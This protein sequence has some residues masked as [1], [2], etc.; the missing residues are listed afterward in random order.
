MVKS[1]LIN[2]MR[3]LWKFRLNIHLGNRPKQN[4]EI[5]LLVKAVFL[6]STALFYC[7][8]VIQI[9]LYEFKKQIYCQLNIS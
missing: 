6:T 1:K 5:L 3:F 2:S 4:I 8:V 7:K 9:R